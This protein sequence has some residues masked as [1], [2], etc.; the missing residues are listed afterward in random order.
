M[1]CNTIAGATSGWMR[2]C[3]VTQ[4]MARSERPDVHVMHIHDAADRDTQ[5]LLELGD[6][7]PLG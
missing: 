1:S 5:L 4:R 7:E 3:S 2:A 6:V